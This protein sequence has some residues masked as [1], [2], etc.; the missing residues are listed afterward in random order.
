MPKKDS[1]SG[2]NQDQS[3]SNGITTKP[4]MEVVPL[5]I[6]EEVKAQA[7]T[8]RIINNSLQVQ[9]LTLRNAAGKLE[10]VT[11]PAKGSISWPIS[12]NL[13]GDFEAKSRQGLISV[14]A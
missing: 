11:L 7:K 8:P 2:E 1:N 13:G 9:S 14:S 3:P 6:A 12:T 4:I 10:E 5:P